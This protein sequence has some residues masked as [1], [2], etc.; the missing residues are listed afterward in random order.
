MYFD[1]CSSQLGCTVTL[2]GGTNKELSKVKHRICSWL[3]SL[4]Q[5]Y[6]EYVQHTPP[7]TLHI[8]LHGLPV[9]RLFV[10]KKC[11]VIDNESCFCTVHVSDRTRNEDE[12]K[13][14]LYILYGCLHTRVSFRVHV[15]AN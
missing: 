13:T 4:Y 14:M 12:V 7:S 9:D 3:T 2:R 8:C 15:L 5:V 10:R 1:G 11:F 6:P